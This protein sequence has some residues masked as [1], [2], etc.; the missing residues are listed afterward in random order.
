[1]HVDAPGPIA[2]KG[3]V[4]NGSVR[5]YVRDVGEGLPIVVLHGGPDFDH[6]YL[7]PEMD[8]L[9]EAFHLVFYD[10]RGRGRSFSGEPLD[11]VTIAT[12]V[13]DLDRVRESFGFGSIALLGHSWGGLLAMEYAIRH[14]ERVSHLILMNSAPASRADAAALRTE[15][16]RRMSPAQTE[17]M[18]ELRSD[19]MF[20]AGDI[21][22]EVEYYRIHFGTTLRNPEHLDAVIR[23]LRSAFTQQGVVAARAI[24]DKL[25]DETWSRD[26]YDLVP[27]LRLLDLPTLIIHGGDD[28]VPIEVIRHIAEAISGSRL[29]VLPNCG[30]FAYLEQPEQVFS[31][32]VAFLTP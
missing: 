26:D 19:P 21:G 6:Q 7:V 17:R 11:D 27:A 15:L 29:I 23:R 28:F 5:L 31:S 30:H 1:V 32:V 13:D 10:Q 14:R 4:R 25:Y 24:E 16:A 9:A 3:F 22:A 8:L 12:E 20:L 18:N 2:R